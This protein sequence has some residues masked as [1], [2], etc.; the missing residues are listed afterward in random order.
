[1]AQI[2]LEMVDEL[3]EKTGVSYA[4]AKDLLT[5]TEGDVQAAI[6]LLANRKQEHQFDTSGIDEVV[7]TLKDLLQKGTAA[8]LVIK[9]EDKTIVNIPAVIGLVGLSAPFFTAAGIGGLVLTGHDIRIENKDGSVINVNEMID[10]AASKVKATGDDLAQK[11]KEA[12]QEAARKAEDL[13]DD[14]ETVIDDLTDDQAEHP[15]D[16][17][18][19]VDQA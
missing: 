2:T 1:M 5:Q 7:A 10:K 17:K 9:K 15:E 19:D 8:K 14:L 12:S 4:E 11:M 3:I 13:G 6:L 18:D 16:V